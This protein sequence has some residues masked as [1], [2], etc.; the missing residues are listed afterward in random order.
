MVYAGYVPSKVA[1][2]LTTPLELAMK[3][4]RVDPP[5][6]ARP[7]TTRRSSHAVRRFRTLRRL[8]R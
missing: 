2:V 6:T 7:H 3:Q 1:T 5:E 8:K 4:A